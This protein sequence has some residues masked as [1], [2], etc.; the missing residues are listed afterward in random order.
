L[1]LDRGQ[2]DKERCQNRSIL[3]PHLREL[4]Q[5]RGLSQRE[6]GRLAKVSPGTIF[7]LENEL[8][9]GYPTTVKKLAAALEVPPSK[10]VRGHLLK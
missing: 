8:R 4:R 2:E 3:L 6:L 7:Q 10:L 5:S 9:G 1:E